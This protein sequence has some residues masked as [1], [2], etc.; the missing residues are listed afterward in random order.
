[1]SKQTRNYFVVLPFRGEDYYLVPATSA[2]EAK[3]KAEAL[4]DDVERLDW[5]PTHRYKA[6]SAKL[7]SPSAADK[8]AE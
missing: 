5:R 8:K 6:S 1:M 7:D 4:D 3:R 2:A